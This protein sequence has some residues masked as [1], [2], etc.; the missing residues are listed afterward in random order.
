MFSLKNNFRSYLI[1]C[2]F[3][4]FCIRNCSLKMNICII[5]I[6]KKYKLKKIKMIWFINLVIC[7]DVL[8]LVSL[9]Y[10]LLFMRILV[11]WEERNIEKILWVRIGVC[12]DFESMGRKCYFNVFVYNCMIV[13]VF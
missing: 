5:S 3:Y 10:F 8:K 7:L 11:F 9:M 13:K 12:K 1:G 4:R 2:F 6:I